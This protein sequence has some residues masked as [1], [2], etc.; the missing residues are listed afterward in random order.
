MKQRYGTSM[1]WIWR[2]LS[3]RA[4][5]ERFKVKPGI[6][7]SRWRTTCKAF[8]KKY[9]FTGKSITPDQTAWPTE[10]PMVDPSVLLTHQNTGG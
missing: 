2:A 5:P 4:A 10:I 9:Y 6:L 8:I 1:V 7:E 3:A